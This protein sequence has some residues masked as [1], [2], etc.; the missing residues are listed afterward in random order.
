LKRPAEVSDN[1][2][3]RISV[4]LSF[5]DEMLCEFEQW[6][7]GREVA[8]VLYEEHNTLTAEQRKAVLAEIG[9][10]RESLRNLRETM[11]LERRTEDVAREMWARSSSF[12]AS[13]VE[14]E[15]KHLR[16]YGEVPRDLA[17]IVDQEIP[18]L[19]EKLNRI[20]DIALD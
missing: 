4:T 12:W 19:V 13:L 10:I 20:S 6:A 17:E 15:S 2:R 16:S 5:L 1:H 7:R 8:S 18:K 3:R 11:S 14:L 9:D